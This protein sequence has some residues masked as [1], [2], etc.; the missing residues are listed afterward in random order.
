MAVEVFTDSSQYMSAQL[1]GVAVATDGATAAYI[2]VAH[3]EDP[4]TPQLDR[5]VVRPAHHSIRI[6]QQLPPCSS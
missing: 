1:V 2:P 3:T 5:D 6:P 4:D